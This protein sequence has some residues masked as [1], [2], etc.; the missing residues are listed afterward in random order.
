VSWSV[1]GSA[2]RNRSPTMA[3]HATREPAE[4]RILVVDDE[5][6]WREEFCDIFEH[7]GLEADEADGEEQAKKL[8]G[9][10]RY[11]LLVLDIFLNPTQVPLDYQRFLTFLQRR[12]PEVLVVVTTAKKLRGH[13]VFAL[14]RLG[15]FGFVD[16]RRM[17]LPELQEM[18]ASLLTLS[19]QGSLERR[20]QRVEELIEQL[21]TS[22]TEVLQLVL[23]LASADVTDCPRLFTLF[24]KEQDRFAPLKV[25]M[26]RYVLTLWCEQPTEEHEWPAA[27]YEFQRPR[28]WLRTIAPYALLV[29]RVLRGTVP[30]AVGVPPVVLPESRVQPIEH[31]LALMERVV[32]QLPEGPAKTDAE[33]ETGS[34]LR[35]EEG[36]SL[37]AFRALLTE[38][39]PERNYGDLRKVASDAGDV[40]WVC[41]EH[42]RA[43]QGR[44]SRSSR[45]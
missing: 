36:A 43:Y 35:A 6:K 11:H 13:E 3:E 20:I 1:E 40:L 45:G 41:P 39:D 26:D 17:Q 8:L 9:E 28:P 38:E 16:K 21:G 42:A 33:V 2:Q 19:T 24:Q 31:Q 14:S 37:R 44:G 5:A 23:K 4:P 7:M 32:S 29:A 10:R 27:T 34:K 22:V 12:H 25:A 30:L 18:V 15:V